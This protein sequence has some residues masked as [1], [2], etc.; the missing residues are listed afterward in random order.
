MN[1]PQFLIYI[2]IS[3]LLLIILY[4]CDIYITRGIFIKN[5]LLY[6]LIF[7]CIHTCL[8]DDLLSHD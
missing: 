6:E 5:C 8:C 2:Y 7:T 1:R 4:F 3:Q